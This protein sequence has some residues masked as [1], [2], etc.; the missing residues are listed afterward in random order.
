MS[1]NVLLY[2]MIRDKKEGNVMISKDEARQKLKKMGFEVMEE[3]SVITVLVSNS[4][5][6]KSVIKDVKEKLLAMDYTGSFGIRQYKG[7][8]NIKSTLQEEVI[9]DAVKLN[10]D[11]DEQEMMDLLNEESVQFSLEDFGIGF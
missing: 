4:V 9:D 1:M 7:E 5:Q 11:K 2:S 3:G 10:V 6:L 8:S